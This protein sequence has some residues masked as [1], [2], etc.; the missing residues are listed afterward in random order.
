MPSRGSQIGRIILLVAI[1]A[2]A[3]IALAVF[4]YR[5]NR[6]ID[7]Q[8]AEIARLTSEVT[9][10][11][12]RTP[13]SAPLDLQAKCADQARKVFRDLGYKPDGPAA[14]ENH[15]NV[16]LNRC[17]MQI[18]NTT[19]QGNVNRNVLDAFEGKE[20]GTYMWQP[21]EGKKYWQVPPFMCDVVSTTGEA[22][23]CH[24]DEEFKSLIRVYL[25]E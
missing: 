3:L 23:T 24:S 16:K 1:L 15:F 8:Q 11:K 4:A 10:T 7:L 21:Q 14:F 19:P 6:E 18:E 2:G 17:F 25:E 12:Q 20:Y 5:Q 13:A 9:T 22:V